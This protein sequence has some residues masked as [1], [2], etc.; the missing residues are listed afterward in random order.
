MN[1]EVAAAFGT[2]YQKLFDQRFSTE[3]L[4]EVA[5]Q[6]VQAAIKN[7]IQT[8][9]SDFNFLSSLVNELQ[10]SDKG[11]GFDKLLKT[12]RGERIAS[13]PTYEGLA[14]LAI[15]EALSETPNYQAMA[16]KAITEW[17][18]YFKRA[19]SWDQ[20]SAKTKA[21]PLIP[22]LPRVKALFDGT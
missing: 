21:Q 8:A 17:F 18:A 22:H 3:P 1:S 15:V 20:T 6:E 14:L 16:N 11:S 4:T 5:A 10:T 7:L 12:L 9:G 19:Y 2:L 13:G